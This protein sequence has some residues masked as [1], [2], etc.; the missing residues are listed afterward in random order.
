MGSN[1]GQ[2]CKEAGLAICEPQAVIAMC[3]ES[4]IILFYDITIKILLSRRICAFDA[5]FDPNN[6]LLIDH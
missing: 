5:T 6:G 3:T 2:S 1:K 4:D